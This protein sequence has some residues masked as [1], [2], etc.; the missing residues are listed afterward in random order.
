VRISTVL[1]ISRD[2]AGGRL[3]TLVISAP[4]SELAIGHAQC[5]IV[6]DIKQ[7]L[8]KGNGEEN[9]AVRVVVLM[10][11]R[12]REVDQIEVQLVK[13][14]PNAIATAVA[15][16]IPVRATSNRVDN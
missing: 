7:T 12:V 1:H 13:T 6:Q 14:S 8:R 16:T 10:D 5:P 11:Y 9:L 2:E 3:Q 4:Q 15:A